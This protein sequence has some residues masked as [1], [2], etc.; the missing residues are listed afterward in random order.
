MP[1]LEELQA[2]VTTVT[3]RIGPAI[4]TIGRDRRGT[5][6]VIGDG[7]VLTN[8][9]NLR[10]RTT[11]VTFADGRTAQAELLGADSEGDLAVLAIDTAAVTPAEWSPEEPATGQV[12][13]AAGRGRQG[14]RVTFGLVS[15]VDRVFRGPRGRRITG[16]VE[17]TAPLARGSS[18]GPIADAEGRLLGINTHRLGDGFYLAIPAGATLRERVD[19]LAAGES[20]T[21][22]RLGISVAPAFVARRL[23]RAVGLPER[24]GLLVRGVEDGSPAAAAGVSSGDLIVSVN[25]ADVR[26]ADDL[27]AVLDEAGDAVELGIVR[28]S[29]ELTVRVTFETG[30]TT[31]EGSA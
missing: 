19:Q 30:G 15:G 13:F 12:L 28:G 1:V 6:V 18:G 8:A 16:S 3:E 10:D 2:A 11:Q 4:V 27:W 17:H 14:L 31:E 21:R 24:D 20:P 25:G 7:R 23:R 22:R 29:D 5:G 9:H 26:T